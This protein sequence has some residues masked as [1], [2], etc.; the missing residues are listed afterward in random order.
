MLSMNPQCLA[1]IQAQA[2]LPHMCGGLN[3]ELTSSGMTTCSFPQE[4]D[5]PTR[6]SLDSTRTCLV[7]GKLCAPHPLPP[8]VSGL[9]PIQNT[10]INREGGGF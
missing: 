6:S 8:T 5:S 9:V 1:Q 4:G 7:Y 10:H 2:G 3:L